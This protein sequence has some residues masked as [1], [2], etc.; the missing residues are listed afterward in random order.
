[1]RGIARVVEKSFELG[2]V[3]PDLLGGNIILPG[4]RR[5]LSAC[6]ANHGKKDSFNLR[7]TNGVQLLREA[8]QPN[9]AISLALAFSAIEALL[10]M[11]SESVIDPLSRNVATLL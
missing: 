4:L 3:N 6:F 9:A 2:R 10:G 11:K 7:L 8:E 5:C 1:M